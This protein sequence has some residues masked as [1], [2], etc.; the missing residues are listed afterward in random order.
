MFKKPFAV[1]TQSKVKGS[2]VRKLRAK[3]LRTYPQVSEDEL[4]PLLP[5]KDDLVAQKLS[6]RSVI[7]AHKGIP[8]FIDVEGHGDICPTVYSLWKLPHMCSSI[9]IHA[10]VSPYLCKKGADVML[11]GVLEES[12]GTFKARDFLSVLAAGNPFPIAVGEM[13]MDREEITE[14]KGR[15]M[16]LVHAYGDEL[17]ASGDKRVPNAGFISQEVTAYDASLE[18]EPEELMGSDGEEVEDDTDGAD[19][20][21]KK[22]KKEKKAKKEDESEEERKRR[23]K[24]EKKEKRERKEAKLSEDAGGGLTIADMDAALEYC[25]CAAVTKT[26]DSELPIS[27]ST[28]YSNMLK[29]KPSGVSVDVKKSSYKKT[30]KLISA[31]SKRKLCKVQDRGG[32]PY[33]VGFDKTKDEIV[34]FKPRKGGGDDASDKKKKNGNLPVITE[35]WKPD[36]ALTPLFHD[37]GHTDK[38][39]L[40]TVREARDVLFRYIEKHELQEG[41]AVRLNDTA[42]CALFKGFGRKTGDEMPTT[43]TREEMFVNMRKRLIP[44]HLIEGLGDEPI[45][46]KGA[47]PDV[48]ISEDRT[49]GHNVTRVSGLETFGYDMEELKDKFKKLFMCTTSVAAMPGKNNKNREVVIQGHQFDGVMD[50]LVNKYGIPKKYVKVSKK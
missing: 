10:P 7:Y 9:T 20:K 45:R 30:N 14:M 32:E 2:D 8:L 12:L 21:K 29:C 47:V 15:A 3:I 6:T 36:A 50:F 1:A 40:F 16:R 11:P 43:S 18:P 37:D 48:R 13:T 38:S 28:F 26:D 34:K 31:M 23:K 27:V 24:K 35:M 5:L 19:G 39:T 44:Y 46:K 41:D 25:F 22:E 4:S 49:H 42:A 17:W 33:I